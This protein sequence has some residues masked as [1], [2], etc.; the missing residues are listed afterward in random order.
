MAC[1]ICPHGR[2]ENTCSRC[3]PESTFERHKREARRRKKTTELTFAQYSQI[4]S[5]N[6]AWCGEDWEPMVVDRRDSNRHYYFENC[7]PLCKRCNQI[8]W[9]SPEQEVGDHLKKIIA[10]RSAGTQPPQPLPFAPLEE[11]E[12][13]PVEPPQLA[14]LA[15]NVPPITHTW[16]GLSEDAKRYLEGR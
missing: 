8:K 2:R 5:G 14:K 4:V 7:Q 16:E 15:R 13:P 9:D 6:C 3:R 12:Q 10:H 11:P 1:K